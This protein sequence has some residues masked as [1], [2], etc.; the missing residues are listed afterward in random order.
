MRINLLS[1]IAIQK[2]KP[3]EKSFRVSD[4]GNLYFHVRPN[5]SRTWE[6]RYKRRHT[7]KPT[8]LGL[9]AY[10]DVSLADAR[11]R[12]TAYRKMIGEGIDPKL[13]KDQ[14]KYVAGKS[15]ASTLRSVA[16]MWMDAKQGMLK[17]KTIRDNW[18][19][20]EKY[21]FPLLGEMPVESITAPIAIAAL[22]PYEKQGLLETVKR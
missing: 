18:R 11:E 10:P 6:F 13:H 21:A 19:K 7:G 22:K 8:I 17:E 16:E 2:L 4:G 15:G 20:L 5:G 12:A 1:A 9:G 3:K 14:Q